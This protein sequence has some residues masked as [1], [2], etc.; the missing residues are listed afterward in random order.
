MKYFSILVLLVFC[1][2]NC[3]PD[4]GYQTAIQGKWQAVNWTAAGSQT[5]STDNVSFD[6]QGD[7]YSAK[8]GGRDES[9]SFRIQGDKL[10][11]HA[12][13]QQEIMV[14][15]QRL[16]A[17]SMVFEMNRG[18]TPELMTLVKAGGSQ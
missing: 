5:R 12:E 10:Y 4:L 1:F 17:D 7:K 11:T 8:L 9:G 15:I 14:K 18:G 3:A 6:F 2:A 13:G 16:T